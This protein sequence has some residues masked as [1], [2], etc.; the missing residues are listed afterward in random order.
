MSAG[1]AAEIARCCS[2]SFR[3]SGSSGV[4]AAAPSLAMALGY[5]INDALEQSFTGDLGYP[6]SRPTVVACCTAS[7]REKT[8][9]FR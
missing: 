2:A 1:A 3:S 6:P 5:D 9:S 7:L 8:P 4:A